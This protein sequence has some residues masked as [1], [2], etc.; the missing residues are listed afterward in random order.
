MIILIKRF[1]GVI[2]GLALLCTAMQQQAIAGRIIDLDAGPDNWRTDT[3]SVVTLRTTGN[4]LPQE[5]SMWACMED[6]AANCE[7]ASFGPDDAV[8]RN[9]FFLP[10]TSFFSPIRVGELS[11]LADDLLIVTI[12]NM[13]SFAAALDENKAG[14]KPIPLKFD[15]VRNIFSP[16]LDLVLRSG[17]LISQGS[18]NNIF[19]EGSSNGIEIG[20]F[21]GHFK[22][23]TP[24]GCDD[25]DVIDI[26]NSSRQ[27]CVTNRNQ[28]YV[29][30][31]GEIR[32]VS[33]PT[34]LTLLMVGILGLFLRRRG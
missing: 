16:T 30:I 6:D 33:E 1:T 14:S 2:F 26:P 34:T 8:F 25:K 19:F 21:D 22:D 20:A 15:I 28:S 7:N 10:S 4:N 24:G 13:F 3:G 31:A 29:A 27:W 18:L 17:T 5:P 23:S 11:I 9:S 32:A 12:N